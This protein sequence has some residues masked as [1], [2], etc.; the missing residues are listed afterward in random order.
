MVLRRG[1]LGKHRLHPLQ[2]TADLAG[3]G[4]EIADTQITGLRHHLIGAER[5]EQDNLGHNSPG[6][7]LPQDGQPVLP[8]QN[9]VH[10]QQIRPA[11]IRQRQY[12][13]PVSRGSHYRKA[14]AFLNLF[15]Q[16]CAEFLVGVC[17]QY[18]SSDFHDLPLSFSRI[19]EL[20][21]ILEGWNRL[22]YKLA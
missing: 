11:F 16:H 9:D 2:Q 21:R 17:Q 14:L 5:R 20:R 6:F 13:R 15:P 12:L 10:H 4:Q 18:V 8:R 22:F 1:G 3:L 7:Q 19:L